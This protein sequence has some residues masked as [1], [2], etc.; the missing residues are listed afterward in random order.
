MY[1]GL[2]EQI[3]KRTNRCLSLTQIRRLEAI[4]VASRETSEDLQVYTTPGKEHSVV[5]KKRSQTTNFCR[6][7]P[8][9][10][11]GCVLMPVDPAHAE[12]V[13]EKAKTPR[14]L[15]HQTKDPESTTKEQ[16]KEVTLL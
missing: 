1:D 15:S 16:I 7:C 12:P 10:R 5:G 11:V 9:S 2:Q 14:S 6:P 13:G 3:S 4:A 8:H